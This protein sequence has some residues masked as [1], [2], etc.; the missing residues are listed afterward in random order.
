[1]PRAHL[2]ILG[3]GPLAD[4]L[5]L[6]I[7]RQGYLLE[8]APPLLT[9]LHV[10][11]HAFSNGVLSRLRESGAVEVR[12][13]ELDPTDE[14]ALGRELLLL[15]RGDTPATAI[16]C[17]GQEAGQGIAIARATLQRLRQ[18]DASPLTLIAYE[19]S[20]TSPPSENDMHVVTRDEADVLSTE[21]SRIDLLAQ[22]IHEDYRRTFGTPGNP[23]S[24]EWL[25]LTPAIQD[26]NRLV[27]EHLGWKLKLAGWNLVTANEQHA[28]ELDATTVELMSKAEHARWMASQ[29]VDGWRAGPTRNNELL[30]HPSLIS[31]E[32]LSESEREKDRAQV[33]RLPALLGLIG[34]GA[35]SLAAEAG[36]SAPK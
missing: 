19:L 2:A 33:R 11:A 36:D 6:G 27:A 15:T 26:S 7:A 5:A 35:I 4:E 8:R 29:M 23:T 3:G 1:M 12:V 28:S 21:A 9:L 20:G 22:A 24:A 13:V 17:I 34:L 16:H 10:G 32:E 25:Q 30:I 14:G 31:W 18:L